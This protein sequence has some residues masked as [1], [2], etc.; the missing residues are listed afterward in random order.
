[1]S[2]KYFTIGF[3]H[4]TSSIYLYLGTT[5]GYPREKI[6]GIHHDSIGNECGCVVVPLTRPIEILQQNNSELTSFEEEDSC[7]RNISNLHR[8]SD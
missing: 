3:L 8:E 5:L 2:Q 7:V 6:F 1:M 4:L